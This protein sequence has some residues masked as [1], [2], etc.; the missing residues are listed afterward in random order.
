[1]EW[2]EERA[3]LAGVAAALAD[4]YALQPLLPPAPAGAP[5][6]AAALL[7]PSSPTPQQQATAEEAAPS[8]GGGGGGPSEA[9]AAAARELAAR[10]WVAQHVVLPALRLFLRP[11][12]ERGGDGSLVGLTRLEHLYRVFE[13]C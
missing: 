5:A 8:G 10:E 13:R 2:G 4:Y 6:G 3:C 7:D 11:P 12:R 9:E 1:M